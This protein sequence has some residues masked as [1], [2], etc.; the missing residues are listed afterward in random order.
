MQQALS[1]DFAACLL[2]QSLCRT[3]NDTYI[4]DVLIRSLFSLKNVTACLSYHYGVRSGMQTYWAA[5]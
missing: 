4:A 3:T 5:G 1:K 2:L